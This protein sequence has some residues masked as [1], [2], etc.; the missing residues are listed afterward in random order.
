MFKNYLKIALRNLRKQKIYSIINISGLAIGMSCFL[1]IFMYIRFELSFDSYHENSD[2]IYRLV[3][4]YKSRDGSRT[5]HS[6]NISAHLTKSLKEEFPEIVDMTRF[7]SYTWRETALVSSGQRHFYENRFFLADPSFF[8]VFSFN[9]IKGDPNTCLSGINSIVI[10][11]ETADRYFGNEDPIGKPLS[12]K[13]LGQAEFIVTGVIENVPDNSHFQFD[14]IAPLNSGNDLY[15]ENF[16]ER[17]S[18][19]TY[20]LLKE[21][22]NFS[23]LE[24]K[25]PDYVQKHNA[26]RMESNLSLQPLTRIHLHSQLSREIETAGDIN[27]IYF[28]ALIGILILAISCINYINLATAQSVYRAK[29]VSLRKV[30]NRSL[31]LSY[32]LNLSILSLLTGIVILTGLISG[33]YPAVIISAFQPGKVLKRTFKTKLQNVN[34]RNLLVIFQYTVS[35]AFII[36]TLVINE[37]MQFIRNTNTGYD[38]ENI[39]VLHLK[40]YESRQNY[41]LFKNE[42]VKNTDIINVSGSVSLPSHPPVKHP[43]LKKDSGEEEIQV[44]WNGVDFDFIDTYGCEIVSGR[45]FS[46]EF[47]TDSKTAYIINETAAREFG[48][49]EPIGKQIQL[50]NKGLM[51]AEYEQGTV[52][53]VVKDFHFQSFH[54]EIEPLVVNIYRN[55]EYISVKINAGNTA[56]ALKSIRTTWEEINPGRPFEYFFFDEDFNRIYRTE[57]QTGRIFRYSTILALLI[58]SLGLFGLASFKA[59]WRIKEIGIRKVLGASVPSILYMF[60]KESAV[61]IALANVIAWPVAYFTMNKWLQEFAYKINMPAEIFLLATGVALGIAV[62]T[63]SFQA[64]RAA[65]TNPVNTLK[66][67]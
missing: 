65:V 46:K 45:D 6:P 61:L 60:F 59:A 54:N 53:G 13:N 34:S 18:F 51:R 56:N 63:V 29:E 9:F 50:S 41:N 48:W 33:G 62:I 20:L 38:R 22:T 25:F 21:G 2:R 37:Q 27:T 42:L 49:K 32:F 40:D 57:E 24:K 43:L 26:G 12:I 64:V 31:E 1:L 44:Y 15:W 8:T 14:L 58:A 11:N 17:N 28:F 52:I 47:P 66:Y 5:I 4:S 35:I 55:F 10:T 36:I 16:L 30:V 19:Y 3:E 39:I 7:F 67:E 23:D